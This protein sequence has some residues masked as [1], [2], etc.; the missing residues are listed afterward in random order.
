MMRLIWKEMRERWL[1]HILWILSMLIVLMIDYKS[2]ISGSNHLYD[3]DI[4][5]L[6]IIIALF[7]GGSAYKSELTGDRILFAYS[8]PI[9]WW[10][11]LIAKIIPGTI[12]VLIT[13]IILFILY[14]QFF[15]DCY[16]NYISWHSVINNLLIVFSIYFAFYLVGISSSTV[17]GGILGGLFTIIASYIIII[18]FAAIT[19]EFISDAQSTN[20]ILFTAFVSVNI[21]IIIS[22]IIL[23]RYNA[24]LKRSERISRF[25]II[26]AFFVI[27]GFIVGIVR[28]K[29]EKY[30]DTRNV[31]WYI[32]ETNFSPDLKYISATY[33]KY[34]EFTHETML[35][36][37]IID[38][39]NGKIMNFPI[40]ADLKKYGFKNYNHYW[41]SNN[42]IYISESRINAVKDISPIIYNM[43]E[44]KIYPTIL[45]NYMLEDFSPDEKFVL[46]NIYTNIK[47]R[48]KRHVKRPSF[49]LMSVFT[50]PE[51]R[52]TASFKYKLYKRQ[53]DWKDNNTVSFIDENGKYQELHLNQIVKEDK[54]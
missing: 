16:S 7:I 5:V 29:P 2:Y 37:Q 54:K 52:E 9:A 42:I 11:L 24:K 34:N 36:N 43:K 22:G 46:G 44:N 50:F 19:Y 30:Q 13:P 48:K 41:M 33:S 12:A 4:F 32:F 28:N 45:L 21:G 39:Q 3:N 38:I 26:F 14:Y 1:L 53:P 20:K 23:A 40:D 6:P 8:R 17:L 51:M 18:L 27:T 49:R 10:K 35:K 15:N 47:T 25:C 31:N